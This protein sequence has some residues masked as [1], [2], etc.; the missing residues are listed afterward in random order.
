[1]VSVKV[2]AIL[3]AKASEMA[4]AILSAMAL[5]RSLN[6]DHIINYEVAAIILFKS[7]VLA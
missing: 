3:S 4:S 5:A 2:S 7:T 1:M 6:C